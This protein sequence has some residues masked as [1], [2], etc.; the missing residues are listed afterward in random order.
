MAFADERHSHRTWSVVERS[1]CAGSVILVVTLGCAGERVTTGGGSGGAAGAAGAGGSA[2]ALHCDGGEKCC[3]AKCLKVECRSKGQV[4]A[5][6]SVAGLDGYLPGAPVVSSCAPID[7]GVCCAD[8]Y[9]ASCSCIAGEAFCG[10]CESIK[11]DSCPGAPKTCS[12]FE[13]KSCY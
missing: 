8:S 11:V 12:A 5:C 7:G 2:G 10:C 3:G 6:G 4:C 9:Y 1:V 13:G